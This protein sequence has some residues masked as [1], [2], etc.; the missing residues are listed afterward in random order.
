MDYFSAPPLLGDFINYIETI[1]GKSAK[2][3]EEYFLDLRTF[4]RFCGMRFKLTDEKV[5]NNIDINSFS[6]DFLQR[7]KLQ[8]LH[9]FISFVDRIKKNNNKTKARK[10]AS[11]RSFFKYLYHVINAIEKNPAENLESPKIEARH[12][13]HLT[14]D[15]AKKLLDSIEGRYATRDFAIIMTFL[16]CGMRL[17]ELVGIDISSIKD[18]TLT[19]VGKGN[20]E[21][22][23]YLNDSVNEAINNYLLE[24]PDPADE[25][26]D[27]LFLSSRKKRISPKAIQHLLRKHLLN[28]GLVDEKYSPHKL[29]HTAATLMYQHGNVDIRVLQEILGHESVSTTQ[30]YTHI[31]D[32]RLKKAVEKNPLSGFT[33][34]EEKI[35][36]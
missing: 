35:N 28:A 20:K 17:S 22:T 4:Y 14:L 16:N 11:L 15:D 30:I 8:D 2:T 23:V 33:K 24:R 5:F 25:N 29:R 10:V 34:K 7:I 32:E 6:E 13:I 31:N 21:R 1:K 18:D 19:V 26:D 36:K 27:A 3:A 12:P 9:S